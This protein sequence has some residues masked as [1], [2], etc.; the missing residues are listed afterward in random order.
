MTTSPDTHTPPP[1]NLGPHDWALLKQMRLNISIAPYHLDPAL[2]H[3]DRV[4]M[5]R[6]VRAGLVTYYSDISRYAL[7]PDIDAYMLGR[8]ARER[9]RPATD[10]PHDPRSERFKHHAWNNGHAQLVNTRRGA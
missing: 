8:S 5:L 1:L 3:H 7:H 10:N 4:S 2:N 6:L 9:G